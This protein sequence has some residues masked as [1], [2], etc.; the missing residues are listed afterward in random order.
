MRVW[1]AALIAL[2]LFMAGDVR[3]QGCPWAAWPCVRAEPWAAQ[4]RD[5]IAAKAALARG[6]A[7]FMTGNFLRSAEATGEAFRRDPANLE[8]AIW[9]VAAMARLGQYPAALVAT[10]RRDGTELKRWP[11]PVL[12]W[13]LGRLDRV[14]LQEL[15]TDQNSSTV[16]DYTFSFFY[17]HVASVELAAG[18]LDMAEEALAGILDLGPGVDRQ[19]WRAAGLELGR[20]IELNDS[21]P[22]QGTK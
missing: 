6:Q 19:I 2:G 16:E 21:K 8:A 5:S 4:T 22:R 9:H 18:R 13:F 1:M 10:I 15:A 3:A 7:D 11:G 20:V 17:F 14:A 12:D